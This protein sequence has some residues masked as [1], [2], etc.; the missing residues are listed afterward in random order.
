MNPLSGPRQQQQKQQQKQKTLRIKKQGNTLEFH[1]RLIEAT[2]GTAP[3]TQGLFL[4]TACPPLLL[5]PLQT[6]PR[7]NCL[8]VRGTYGLLLFN[9]GHEN[10]EHPPGAPFLRGTARRNPVA[11]QGEGLCRDRGDRGAV[12]YIGNDRTPRALQVER[13]GA[14]HQDSWRRD[15][16]SFGFHGENLPGTL[17]KDV[18][19]ERRA[20]PCGLR[21]RAGWGNGR[22]RF[23]NDH[24]IYREAPCIPARPGS[25]YGLSCGA[26][27]IGRQHRSAS[28]FDG[29]RVSPDQSR[30]LWEQC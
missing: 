10:F 6:A 2:E 7:G 13:R 29:W 14:H 24:A 21:S 11:Y 18:R 4:I 3:S 5:P 19:G 1:S 25:G 30:P 12:L 16:R 8:T 23:G 17:G 9:T 20:G 15:G 28:P 27:R 26:G 22:A